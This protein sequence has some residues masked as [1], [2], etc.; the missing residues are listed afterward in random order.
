MAEG[1]V[2]TWLV[3]LLATFQQ[4][5]GRTRTSRPLRNHSTK[6]AAMSTTNS[7]PTKAATSTANS[8]NLNRKQPQPHLSNLATH[9]M[10]K[11]PINQPAKLS[12]DKPAALAI[13]QSVHYIKRLRSHAT[14]HFSQTISQ[15]QFNNTGRNAFL[16]LHLLA[17]PGLT[18]AAGLTWATGLTSLTRPTW[19]TR[20][21]REEP[22]GGMRMEDHWNACW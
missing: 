22:E 3:C 8:R 13:W 2:A 4:G 11:L 15:Q 21:L 10:A 20:L 19:P 18:W 12:T 7:R 17:D 9:R 1:T 6:P 16:F 5:E 14:Q